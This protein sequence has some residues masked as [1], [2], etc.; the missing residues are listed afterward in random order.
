L[1]QGRLPAWHPSLAQRVRAWHDEPQGTNDLAESAASAGFPEPFGPGGPPLPPST[2]K[3]SLKDDWERLALE[4]V[5][6]TLV[7]L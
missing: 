5:Q 3:V 7:R 4:S 1:D 2:R 6:S